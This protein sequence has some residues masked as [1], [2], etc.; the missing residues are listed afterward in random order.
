MK[1]L[2]PRSKADLFASLPPE[3]PDDPLPEIRNLIAKTGNK[4]VVLDDDPT[5]TQTVHGIAVLTEWSADVLE[6]EL[7]SEGDAFYLLTNSRSLPATE[8][9]ALNLEISRNLVEAGQRASRPF[10]IV[11]RSDSTLR[12]HFPL[13]VDALAEGLNRT[14]DAILLIPAFLGSGRYT[15]GDIHYVED[16]GLLFPSGQTEFA[17]D[18]SFG[19]RASNLRHWVDEKTRGRIPASTINAISLE[20]IRMGGPDRVFEILMHL[21]QG[22][23]CVIN[24]ASERD[25]E[26]V[27]WA[28]IM[29][30]A[31]G[32]LLAYR[33]AASFAR[34]RAGIAERTLLTVKDLELPADGGG[35]VIVGSY[36]EKTTTQVAALLDSGVTGL[37]IDAR[38]LLSDDERQNEIRRI[39]R[40]ADNLLA[41]GKDVVIYTSRDLVTG[42]SPDQSLDI[43]N[44]ISDGLVTVV[45]NLTASPRYIV[46]KGGITSSDIATKA[47]HAK[48]AHVM[49]QVTPGVPVWLLGSESRFPG[50]RYVVFPGNVGS[51]KTLLDIVQALRA[52]S[53]S[54][55][56]RT[57]S[58]A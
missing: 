57:M 50:L 5:G 36:V 11:S 17:R 53:D 55:H 42:I 22:S 28:S 9:R 23:V 27:A 46:A 38:A 34:A 8:A 45:H 29:A 52:P 51:D 41:C 13:E 3:W 14:F 10:S 43:G 4:L 15:I 58:G 26:V 35:L 32:R 18:A 44:Q 19:Y 20:D 48:R 24:A 12:G 6:H 16:D 56:V 47:L 40:A 37:E 54:E 2:E 33:T 7:R 30:E 49:G 21:P 39:A 1:P 25:L 31:A